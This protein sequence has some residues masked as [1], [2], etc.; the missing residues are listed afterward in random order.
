MTT[1]TAA[2]TDPV[3]LRDPAQLLAA[4]PYLFG[5]RPENSVVLLGHRPPGNVVGLLLRADLPARKHRAHQAEALAQRFASSP[6][7]GVTAAVIGGR[8]PRGGRPPH[9][10]FVH[11][12]DRALAGHGLRMLHALWAPEIVSGAPWACY[13]DTVCGGVLPDP[14]GTV[15]A[16]VT[17]ESGQVAFASRAEMERQLE[18]RCPE[19][20][21]RRAAALAALSTPPWDPADAVAAGGAEIRAALERQRRGAGPPTDDQAVRLA[22]ALADKRVRDACLATALPADTPIARE[23]EALWR[24]LVCELP[25]PHRAE[26]ACLLGYAAY[27]RSDGTFAGMALANALAAVPGH[28]L[29][30]LLAG[31]LDHGFT[32]ESLAGLARCEG[33]ADLGLSGEPPD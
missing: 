27:M 9:A 12:L 16:A 29:S 15:M 25:A 26:A 11:H 6:H 8:P 1:S 17:T 31:A 13:Q 4:F 7:T 24:T 2:G 18:P 10:G 21:A 32:P 22:C 3:D 23:A 14:R 28:L 30:R 5:F 19:A 33:V 20:L